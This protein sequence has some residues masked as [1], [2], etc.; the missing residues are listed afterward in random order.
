[1]KCDV[2]KQ[3]L[4]ALYLQSFFNSAKGLSRDS[5]LNYYNVKL[6]SADTNMN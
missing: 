3:L 6:R 1:M 5:L 4:Y 2:T